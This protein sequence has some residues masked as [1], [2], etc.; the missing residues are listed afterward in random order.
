MSEKDMGE[1]RPTAP[2]PECSSYFEDIEVASSAQ[3][4]GY[5]LQATDY[6][7]H[8]AGRG[9][10]VFPCQQNKRPFT[11][12]GF[13][14]ASTDTDTIMEW[15]R[16]WPEA[17]IG[18][19][20]GTT[21]AVLDLD[22][23]YPEAQ[24]WYAKANLP[25]T[26]THV[27]RSGGRHLFFKPRAD[28]KCSAGKIER[29]VDSRGAGGYIIWWPAQ[30]F[31]VLHASALAEVP[32]WIMKKLNPPPPKAIPVSELPRTRSEYIRQIDGIAD[33]AAHAPIGQRD[34]TTFWSACRLAE[35]VKQRVLDERSAELLIINAAI[36]NGLG[37]KTGREKFRNAMREVR[38]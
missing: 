2:T 19:P 1:E 20:T 21:F 7:L 10:P 22:L 28:F 5:M 14:D 33:T 9:T 29:G 17:L 35:L 26:R 11:P 25:L 34:T 12:N 37:E 36:Q 23:Q 18:V 32:D 27:T 6:A 8:L 30:G 4:L 24:A 3:A 38:P 15:W 13:K 16:H 31:D